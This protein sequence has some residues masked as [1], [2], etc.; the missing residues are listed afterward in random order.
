[1]SSFTTQL[2]VEPL[3]DGAHWKLTEDF[4]YYVGE[5]GSDVWISVPTGYITDFGSI[6]RILWSLLPPWG[7]YGKA[8]V[9]HDYLCDGRS[10][11]RGGELSAVD[12]KTA[13]LIFLEAMGVLDVNVAV[14][15]TMYASV[16]VYGK[17]KEL[18]DK[19]KSW[20]K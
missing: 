6:P 11:V 4:I 19:V 14:R 20:V 15:Y 7:T 18:I 13:D 1:M 8:T 3:D 17:A 12:R 2:R 9:I 5:I 10:M 16:R